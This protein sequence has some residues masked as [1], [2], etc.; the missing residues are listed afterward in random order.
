MLSGKELELSKMSKMIYSHKDYLIK[1]T[2]KD[3]HAHCFN[4][5]STD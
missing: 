1:P 2:L 3:L 4:S 5:L